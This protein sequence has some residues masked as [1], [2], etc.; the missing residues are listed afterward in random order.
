M[1]N[2]NRNERLIAILNTDQETKLNNAKSRME[3]IVAKQHE[4]LKKTEEL[5]D[6]LENIKLYQQLLISCYL[7][8]EELLSELNML[9]NEVRFEEEDA[10]RTIVKFMY[11]DLDLNTIRV[12]NDSDLKAK[13]N[14]ACITDFIEQLKEI[15]LIV[16][17]FRNDN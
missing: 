10:K 2:M 1:E 16:E 8:K 4:V 17:N 3:S 13:L 15:K 11:P 6:K 12:E 14:E 5:K 9:I 7:D